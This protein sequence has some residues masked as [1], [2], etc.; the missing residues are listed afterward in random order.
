[1]KGQ[2]SS[3]V[4]RGLGGSNTSPATQLTGYEIR[5]YLL[6]K[7][8]RTCAYCCKQDIPLQVEHIIPRAKG[9]TNRVSNLALACES[10]NV[11]KG[12]KDIHKYLKHQPD[13]L[14]RIL[15]H[16]KVPLKDAAAVNITRWVL[17]NRLQETGLPVEVGTGGCT[18]WNRTVRNLPK[19]HWMDAC[20]VGASTPEFLKV[21]GIAPLLVTANGR[22]SRQ[23]CHMNKYGFPRTGPKKVK[24]IKGFQTGDIVR[25]VV[26][27]GKKVGTYIG[28]ASVR[29]TGRFDIK[30]AQGTIQGISHHSCTLLHHCDGYSYAQAKSVS[31]PIG[32]IST[33]L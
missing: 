5:E 21:S 25:A 2:L 28:R 17:Y 18:K 29:A 3:T 20:C 22:G 7:W 19:T 30:V 16:A 1:M 8:A 23:L 15:A 26:T 33:I 13:L 10:C 14:S 27:K 6:E 11:A 12:T 24:T 4:L 31:C 32:H 9:G